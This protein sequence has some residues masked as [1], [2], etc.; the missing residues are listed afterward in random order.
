MPGVLR[1]MMCAARRPARLQAAGGVSLLLQIRAWREACPDRVR[2]ERLRDDAQPS[3]SWRWD[4]GA[5]SIR[6]Q[7]ILR[8]SCGSCGTSS[9]L[10]RSCTS[11]APPSACTCRSRRCRGRSGSSSVSSG[12]CCS[13]GPRGASSS[14]RP[15]RR[16]SSAARRALAEVDLAVDEA[17]RAARAG[18]GVVAI[19]HGPFSRSLAAR[20]V[21]EVGGASIRTSA[22]AGGGRR[23]GALSSGSRPMSW[24]C[25]VV[26]ETP[27]AARRHGVR[28]D[29]LRDEPLL[30][31]LPR[32]TAT[33][34]RTRSRSAPSPP[35][36]CCCRASR[37]A[38]RSTRGCAPSSEPP[39]TSSSGR[40]RR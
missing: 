28:V 38:G 4:G 11:G 19:G 25:A 34:T 10:P 30:A 23:A 3:R 2:S 31:A 37:P 26:L 1:R 9:R 27:A 12:W 24:P 36:A 17:R 8:S 13:S 29:A 20:V 33:P 39:V 7:W 16:C 6:R 32:R 5:V 35:S 15:G 14:R 40:W 21:E 22:P 18:A